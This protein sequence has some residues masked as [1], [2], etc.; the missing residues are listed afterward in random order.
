MFGG[1]LFSFLHS[2]YEVNNKVGM[3]QPPQCKENNPEKNH[4]HYDNC[5]IASELT[6]KSMDEIGKYKTKLKHENVLAAYTLYE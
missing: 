6:L 2:L 1:Y 4:W 3:I 5:L